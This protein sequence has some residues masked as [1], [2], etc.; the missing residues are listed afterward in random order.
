MNQSINQ[1]TNQSINAENRGIDRISGE[2]DIREN[3]HAFR[4][5]EHVVLRHRIRSATIR[6]DRDCQS[7]LLCH[8]CTMA[9]TRATVWQTVTV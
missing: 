8:W 5:Y 4:R 1:S 9:L 3:Y 6:N 7:V 2:S